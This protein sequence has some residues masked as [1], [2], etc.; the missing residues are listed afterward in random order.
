M[1]HPDKANV[2]FVVFSASGKF[3]GSNKLDE[4]R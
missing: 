3:A 4:D 1:W 2:K